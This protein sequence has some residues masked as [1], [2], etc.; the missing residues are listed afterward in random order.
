MPGYGS[1][2]GVIE[3]N[4]LFNSEN[5]AGIKAAGPTAA[6]GA[7][8]VTIRR[9][10]ITDAAAGVIV[11]YG[12]NRVQ[13]QHNLIGSQDKRPPTGARWVRNYDA[14][15]IGNHVQGA[16]NASVGTV[17]WGFPRSLHSTADSSRSV[18]TAGTRWIHPQF[19]KI[20]SCGGFH[21]ANSAAA[22]AGRFS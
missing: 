1:G 12:T 10:T 19:D 3:H 7:A 21:P 15:V 8:Q 13:L 11:G 18:R 2:P 17:V 6:T 9:N 4:L 20:N 22:A 5:G 16:G 14:A